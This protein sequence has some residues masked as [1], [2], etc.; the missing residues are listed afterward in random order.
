[1]SQYVQRATGLA[2]RA[3]DVA[4]TRVLPPAVEYYN[5]TMAKNAEYVVKDPA[6]VDK[7]G[8][9]LVFSNLAKCVRPRFARASRPS[10]AI[11]SPGATRAP[12]RGVRAAAPAGPNPPPFCQPGPTSP[13]TRGSHPHPSPRRRQASRHGRGRAGRDEGGSA[14][15]GEP[16][17]AS[18]D[19]GARPLAP[20][21]P[22]PARNRPHPLSAW[23]GVVSR[24]VS[25]TGTA[26]C[27][28]C[29]R[30][31]RRGDGTT[32]KNNP[33]NPAPRASP[34]Q[35]GVAALFTAEVY[36]WFCVGEVVG[37][38]GSLTGY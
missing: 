24:P 17:G 18:H 22:N 26:P 2:S 25:R 8:R 6:A 19:R 34:P 35:V 21:L 32:Q 30:G 27:P 16:H 9:Q 36:A 33:L 10:T 4:K 29:F 28:R 37:R 20:R 14:E 31:S 7:L 15:V 38:G 1:M 3:M 12:P 5:A 23:N 11:D 13:F